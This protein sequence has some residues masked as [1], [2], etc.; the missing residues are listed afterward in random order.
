MPYLPVSAFPNVPLYAWV[1]LALC[2]GLV[3]AYFMFLS[4]QEQ[5]LPSNR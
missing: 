4:A 5:R 2:L 3:A 1:C